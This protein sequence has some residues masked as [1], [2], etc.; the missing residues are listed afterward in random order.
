[1]GAGA[2][3]GLLAVP[4]ERERVGV[5]PEGE[6]QRDREGCARRQARPDGEGAG[7]RDGAAARR[8]LEPQ[9]PGRQEGLGGEPGRCR[10]GRSRGAGPGNWSES[11]PT[12]KLPGLGVKVTSVARSMAMGSERPPL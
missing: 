1:M 3:L 6:E 11:I 7:D 8:R 5:V 2:A 12:R 9:E 4:G 10:P